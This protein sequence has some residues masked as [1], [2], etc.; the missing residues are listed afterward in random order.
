MNNNKKTTIK[1]KVANIF[2]NQYKRL[3]K[4]NLLNDGNDAKKNDNNKYML[5]EI[6]KDIIIAFLFDFGFFLK[7]INTT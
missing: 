5:M 1:V 2:L 7:F 4:L 6:A 3:S